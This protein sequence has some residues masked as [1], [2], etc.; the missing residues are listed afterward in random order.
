MSFENQQYN[1]PSW[2]QPEGA[3]AAPVKSRFHEAMTNPAL[4]EQARRIGREVGSEALKGALENAGVAK[5]DDEGNMKVRKFG[6]VKAVLRPQRTARKAAM[7]AIEGARGSAKEQSF[8]LARQAINS[9]PASNPEAI[10][11]AP[12]SSELP[13]NYGWGQPAELPPPADSW[14]TVPLQPT[15]NNSLPPPSSTEAWR[16]SPVPQ[17]QPPVTWGPPPPQR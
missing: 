4:H 9:L 1:N 8:D 12:V 17:N 10:E 5:F 11:Q 3:L 14:N 2:G 6:A 15:W 13:T 16:Q 7:G